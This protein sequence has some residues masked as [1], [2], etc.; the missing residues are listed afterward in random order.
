MR[1]VFSYLRLLIASWVFMGGVA[2]QFIPTAAATERDARWRER[3]LQKVPAE[4]RDQ[5]VEDRDNEDSH[6]QAYL[7]VCG[8]LLGGIGLSMALRE[9]AYLVG[10]Y[11]R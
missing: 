4:R 5:W 6:S 3:Q 1:L 11:S 7:R 2:L 10:R 9:T 8:V